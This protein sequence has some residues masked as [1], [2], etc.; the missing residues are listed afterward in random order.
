MWPTKQWT[1]KELINKVNSKKQK[2]KWKKNIT[3]DGI[4]KYKYFSD[5]NYNNIHLSLIKNNI[6]LG[7]Y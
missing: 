6:R 5:N 2:T 3:E 7:N 4:N 1:K